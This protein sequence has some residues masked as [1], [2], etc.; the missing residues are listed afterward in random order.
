MKDYNILETDYNKALCKTSEEALEKAGENNAILR[1]CLRSDPFL[2]Q[3]E[4]SRGFDFLAFANNCNMVAAQVRGEISIALDPEKKMSDVVIVSE[5]LELSPPSAG[6][7]PW[8]S[9]ILAISRQS[10][11][12]RTGSRW[13]CI[14]AFCFD[15]SHENVL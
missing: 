2:N 4:E 10:P 12:R 11:W 6:F 3:L 1:D 8:R 9:P 13:F 5:L 15:L 14:F 7:S